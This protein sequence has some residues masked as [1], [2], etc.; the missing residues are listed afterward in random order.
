MPLQVEIIRRAGDRIN[1]TA[2][3]KFMGYQD[4]RVIKTLIRTLRRPHV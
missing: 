3:N 4:S 2:V 1:I